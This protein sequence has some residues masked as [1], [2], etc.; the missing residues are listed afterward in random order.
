MASEGCP[1]GECC[2][3]ILL[4]RADIRELRRQMRLEDEGFGE[5]RGIVEGPA[6]F[7]MWTF[8]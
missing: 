5:T 8:E 3:A 2:E 7:G 1:N 6:E 4:G